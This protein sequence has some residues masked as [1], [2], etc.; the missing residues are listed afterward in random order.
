MGRLWGAPAE[1][2][3]GVKAPAARFGFCSPALPLNPGCSDTSSPFTASAPNLEPASSCTRLAQGTAALHTFSMLIASHCGAPALPE[4]K[5]PEPGRVARPQH[6]PPGRC[7]SG[8]G[9]R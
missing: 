7:H 1:A 3:E 4:C 2:S 6:T 9:T 8:T 5:Q